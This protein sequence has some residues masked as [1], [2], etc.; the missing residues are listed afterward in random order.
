MIQ[1]SIHRCLYLALGLG[2]RIVGYIGL[3]KDTSGYRRSEKAAFVFRV[4][5]KG[6]IP[7]N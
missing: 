7:L 2:F 5:A 1:G 3:Y 6:T 4:E